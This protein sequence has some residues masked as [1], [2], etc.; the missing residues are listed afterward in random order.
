MACIEDCQHTFWGGNGTCQTINGVETKCVCQ[1]TGYLSVNLQDSPSCVSEQASLVFNLIST[2]L[3]L[4]LTIHTGFHIV[5]RL[6]VQQEQASKQD[7]RRLTMHIFLLLSALCFAIFSC[8]H[9]M[10]PGLTYSR[11]IPLLAG[12]NTF[13]M[14]AS[15]SV[16]ALFFHSLPRISKSCC[17]IAHNVQGV[18]THERT[19]RALHFL[20]FVGSFLP[21]VALMYL[22]GTKAAIK[23][24]WI[25]PLL[26]CFFFLPLIAFSLMKLVNLM[27][28]LQSTTLSTG[29]DSYTK[30]IKKAQY[31]MRFIVIFGYCIAIPYGLAFLNS[32][33]M[34]DT[35]LVFASFGTAL[36]MTTWP[37]VVLLVFPG[38][39]Q[40][41]RKQIKKSQVVVAGGQGQ[42]KT[43]SP[44]D[45]RTS[46]SKSP[47]EENNISP[48]N[49][50]SQK[51]VQKGGGIH[52][53]GGKCEQCPA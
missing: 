6:R 13:G 17:P 27:K 38:T 20:V 51:Y 22:A 12:C 1:S 5:Q 33:F 19:L 9:M 42:Q 4:A 39:T 24:L 2:V 15:P 25:V 44:G 11:T 26:G 29:P 40:K 37:H 18:L 23:Y 34:Q 53:E 52:S 43:L 36:L 49:V 35:P 8:L 30:T 14:M 10:I 32:P 31:F 3:G 28:S 21:C 7:A 50:S 16:M 47:M 45:T 48:A 46:F 41:R